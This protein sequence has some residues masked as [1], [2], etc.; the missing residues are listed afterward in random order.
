[1]FPGHDPEHQIGVWNL[2]FVLGFSGFPGYACCSVPAGLGYGSLVDLV[3]AGQDYVKLMIRSGINETAICVFAEV[4][5]FEYVS[6]VEII[7]A[8]W[9]SGQS[10]SP[11][12]CYCT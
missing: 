12:F 9:V 7:H 4:Y 3:Y 5:F 8:W 11:V 1:M 2:L 6:V 10:L